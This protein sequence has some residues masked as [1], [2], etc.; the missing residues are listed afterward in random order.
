MKIYFI[1]IILGFTQLVICLDLSNVTYDESYPV[2]PINC[3]YLNLWKSCT[4][5]S[6]DLYANET[7]LVSVFRKKRAHTEYTR[8]RANL[9]TTPEFIVKVLDEDMTT[10]NTKQIVAVNIQPVTKGGEKIIIGGVVVPPVPPSHA[11]PDL[12]RDYTRF[13][14]PTTVPITRLDEELY[15][16]PATPPRALDMLPPI[17]PKG[18]FTSDLF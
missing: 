7:W 5:L 10:V 8:W 12:P 17:R 1:L 15:L 18:M 13:V 4:E 3:K 11:L 14:P 6:T 9:E 2:C 16:A